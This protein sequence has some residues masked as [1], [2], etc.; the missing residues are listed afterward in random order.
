M[1][2]SDQIKWHMAL[3]LNINDV[4]VREKE[5][6]EARKLDLEEVL[7]ARKLDLEDKDLIS[8]IPFIQADIICMNDTV[9]FLDELMAML[10][11]EDAT[12]EKVTVHVDKFK[13]SIE[14]DIRLARDAIGRNREIDDF[15][16]ASTKT[17][18]NM[19]DKN[20]AIMEYIFTYCL[21]R[22]LAVRIEVETIIKHELDLID[23]KESM[24][25][26]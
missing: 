12:R 7:E 26:H 21:P 6:L 16:G 3:A 20:H 10:N 13:N 8:S 9:R 17:R 14:S 22:A 1:H 25:G 24:D 2:D 19:F 18:I 23:M 15:F 11:E 4:I 5:V